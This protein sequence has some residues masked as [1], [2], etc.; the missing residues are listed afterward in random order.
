MSE[1]GYWKGL[2]AF[3][4]R[5]LEDMTPGGSEFHNAPGRCIE[6]VKA[7]LATVTSLARERNELRNELEATKI[8]LDMWKTT[9]KTW[10]MRAEEAE[11]SLKVIDEETKRMEHDMLEVKR[12]LQRL[13]LGGT[14]G[15]SEAVS[16]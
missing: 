12:H 4:E 6:W 2:Y 3:L 7:R 9:A 10:K 13:G 5:A 11:R 14:D 16:G 8:A 15:A 1:E